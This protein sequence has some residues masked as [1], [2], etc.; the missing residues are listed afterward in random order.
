MKLSKSIKVGALLIMF[1]NLVM[2]VG[3][4]WVFQRMTPSIENIIDQNGRSLQAC[5]GMLALLAATSSDPE[6]Q[7]GIEQQFQHFLETAKNNITETE[8]QPALELIEANYREALRLD[9]EAA[10][11]TIVALQSLQNINWN[12]TYQ[13]DRDAKHIGNAGAWGICFMGIFVFFAALVFKRRVERNL[14]EPFEEIASV[15]T[16]QARGNLMRRCTRYSASADVRKVYSL[17]NDWIDRQ[18]RS[19]P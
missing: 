9:R 13:A 8:E 11:R 1:L 10:A 3:S 2:A 14:L 7:K 19:E 12:A 17:I 16:S 6:T 4:I 5:E 18:E 15:L